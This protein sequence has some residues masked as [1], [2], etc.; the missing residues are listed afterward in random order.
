MDRLALSADREITVS[1][2]IE[3]EG[4]DAWLRFIALI[5]EVTAVGILVAGALVASGLFL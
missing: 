5:I 2:L 3:R 1:Q 4:L